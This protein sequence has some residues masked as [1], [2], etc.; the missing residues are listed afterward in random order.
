MA[1]T[2]LYKL[3]QLF[4]SARI[5]AQFIVHLPAEFPNQ[6]YVLPFIKPSN[7]I[8]IPILT[9]MENGIDRSCMVD[10]VQPVAGIF[11][12]AIDWQR[13]VIDDVQD[14]QRDELLRKVV[15]P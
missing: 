5:P 14:A 4:G 1:G 12:V 7:I 9:I 13:P 15:G 11:P 8:G 10:N 2:V 3:D 6:V